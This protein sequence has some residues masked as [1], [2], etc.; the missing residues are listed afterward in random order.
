M[1]LKPGPVE[2]F[3]LANQNVNESRFI[4]WVKV[5]DFQFHVS[6]Y[7]VLLVILFTIKPLGLKYR[8]E[9]CSRI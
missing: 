4:D 8:L 7:F 1:I 9:R 5:Y 3:L 6:F 2:D